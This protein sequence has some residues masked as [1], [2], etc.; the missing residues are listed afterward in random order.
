MQAISRF[1]KISIV[2]TAVVS[3]SLI[4]VPAFAGPAL[5]SN[6][7]TV[8]LNGTLAESL[9]VSTTASSVNFTLVP[10]STVAGSAAVPITTTWILGPS[11]T[12]I[13][14]YGFFASSAAA[15][16]DGYSTPDNIPSAD[17]LGQVP[18][19][20]PTTYTAFTQTA[21]GFGA[22]SASLLLYTQQVV[23]S[24]NNLVGNRTD[25]L[26][27]EIATPATL[28]AGTYTGT[29]TLQAQAN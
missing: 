25:N 20:T 1:K 3:A 13:K 5:N 23:Q 21:A 29:L 17:V 8:T 10:G 12:S 18:T 9:T 28:P 24:S 27:L 2:A 6:A 7:P 19:G 14:L 22:A 26:S 16:T 4:S 11:R 15:L